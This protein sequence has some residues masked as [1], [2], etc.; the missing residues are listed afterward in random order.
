MTTVQ[1]LE[2]LRRMEINKC[3]FYSPEEPT[4]LL[5]PGLYCHNDAQVEI[6]ENNFIADENGTR[7]TGTYWKPFCWDC[8][9]KTIINPSAIQGIRKVS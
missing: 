4:F 1:Y 7:V 3:H 5:S 6:E 2:S 8:M 9:V